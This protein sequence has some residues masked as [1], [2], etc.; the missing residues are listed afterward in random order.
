[1]RFASRGLE[2][3][4]KPN[5]NAFLGDLARKEGRRNAKNHAMALQKLERCTGLVVLK[6][7]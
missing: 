3:I 2:L 6:V 4:Q 7:E 1:M 5:F